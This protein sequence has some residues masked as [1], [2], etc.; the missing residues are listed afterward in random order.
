M[1]HT[2]VDEVLRDGA[3]RPLVRRP[4][5]QGP[6]QRVAS[7]RLRPLALRHQVKIGDRVCRG[8]RRIPTR[9]R[10]RPAHLEAQS[11]LRP[12]R[13][14]LG[15]RHHRLAPDALVLDKYPPVPHHLPHHLRPPVP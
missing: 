6:D 9:T 10:A 8:Q 4:R 1:P 2:R 11:P 7:P 3:P 5:Q 14:Q 12:G 13:R 15:A